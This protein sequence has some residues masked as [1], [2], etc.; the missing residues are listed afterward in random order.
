MSLFIEKTWR[1]E[2]LCLKTIAFLHEIIE[3]DPSELGS[4]PRTRREA[5]PN[6]TP[7]NARAGSQAAR[8]SRRAASMNPCWPNPNDA[9]TL[10]MHT[11]CQ[12]PL[13]LAV[14]STR[15]WA[16]NGSIGAEPTER[17]L[18]TVEKFVHGG[19]V[20]QKR[21]SGAGNF[22]HQCQ[23]RTSTTM[24]AFPAGPK[25]IPANTNKSPAGQQISR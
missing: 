17:W 4:D 7:L 11:Y 13:D 22:R 5:V 6:P 14:S 2:R 21:F 12:A 10:R 8:R 23:R 9:W 1:I 16:P 15:P 3:F 20:K 25:H 18:K 19:M 24:H